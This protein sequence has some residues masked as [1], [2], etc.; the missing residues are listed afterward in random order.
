MTSLVVLLF[1]NAQAERAYLY[2]TSSDAP[3]TLQLTDQAVFENLVLT[4]ALKSFLQPLRVGVVLAKYW[5]PAFE[6]VSGQSGKI[7]TSQQICCCKHA[8]G[9]LPASKP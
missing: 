8:K 3:E 5:P 6:D 9:I 1:A 2:F 4:S 7:R